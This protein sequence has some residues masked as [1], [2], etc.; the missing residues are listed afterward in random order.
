MWN[1][2]VHMQQ[3]EV[4]DFCYLDHSRRQRQIVGR[5]FKQRISRYLD[6]VIAD[7]RHQLCKADRL[8]IRNE[9]DIM[10]ALRQLKPQLGGDHT[11]AAVSRITSDSYSHRADVASVLHGRALRARDKRLDGRIRTGIQPNN[12]AD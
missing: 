1:C 9:V 6:L 11:A 7:I 4:V 8:G 12:S 2:V 3:V 5:I 10:A